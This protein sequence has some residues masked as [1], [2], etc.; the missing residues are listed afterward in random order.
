MK[1]KYFIL[2]LAFASAFLFSSCKKDN[3]YVYD[4]PVIQSF[5]FSVPENS[6]K[7][8]NINNNNYFYATVDAPEITQSVFDSGIVKIYRVFNTGSTYPCQM[9]MPYVRHNEV[10]LGDDQWAFYTE[11]VDYEFSV[12]S[13]TVFY[14]ASD[15]E[16]EVDESI[17]PVM[18]EFRCAVMY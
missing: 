7:Y 18:M 8:S 3:I 12:G 9:E 14:T 1:V 5:Y 15:F 11:T 17:N 13:I 4:G 6:W 16:Y 2:M 10:S